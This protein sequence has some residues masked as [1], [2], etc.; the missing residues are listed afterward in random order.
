L[1]QYGVLQLQ[2]KNKPKVAILTISPCEYVSNKSLGSRNRP[3][4]E[5]YWNEE[6]KDRMSFYK[7]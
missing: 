1:D 5:I 2:A 7:N 4:I 6:M 3:K